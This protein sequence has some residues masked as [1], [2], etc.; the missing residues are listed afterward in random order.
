MPGPGTGSTRGYIKKSP[1]PPAASR[2]P[3]QSLRATL[4]AGPERVDP[5]TNCT[6]HSSG[7]Q[8]TYPGPGT[9]I[10]LENSWSDAGRDEGTEFDRQAA[11]KNQKSNT[12]I[13]EADN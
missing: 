6:A 11:L 7:A 5:L 8:R 4:A 1:V 12:I 9:I 13:R 10:P 3:W 2:A